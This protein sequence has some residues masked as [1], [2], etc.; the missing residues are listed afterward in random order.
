MIGSYSILW[1]PFKWR[2]GCW[3]QSQIT[4]G[5]RENRFQGEDTQTPGRYS[6]EYVVWTLLWPWVCC[7]PLDV[8]V[9]IMHVYGCV[10]WGWVKSL[11][12]RKDQAS[13]TMFC[14]SLDKTCK[15]RPPPLSVSCLKPTFS[16]GFSPTG[17][18]SPTF[19]LP[20]SPLESAHFWLPWYLDPLVISWISYQFSTFWL[21][22]CQAWMYSSCTE[23]GWQ[24]ASFP[25]T[26]CSCPSVSFLLS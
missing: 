9:R 5:A 20:E 1:K 3:E 24:G 12:S 8:Y 14:H 13:L 11:W 4:W 18:K 26:S 10:F 7:K 2:V 23:W 19:F 6:M 21:P 22:P 16:R 15:I 17:P 25:P